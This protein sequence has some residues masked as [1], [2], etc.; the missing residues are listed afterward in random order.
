[1]SRSPDTAISRLLAL[2]VALMLMVS[3][4][5]AWAQEAEKPQG[6]GGSSEKGR[7]EDLM[8]V[9]PYVRF[10]QIVVPIIEGDRVT[11]QMA[12]TLTLQLFDAK[13]RAV[14]N[15]KR[16]LLTDA[17][18]KFLYGYFQQRVGLKTPINQVFL[19]ERLRQTAAGIVGP[20]LVKE[21]LIQQIYER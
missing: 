21:V 16:P 13:S 15:E 20:D 11:K 18:V 19:K 4:A 10:A 12:L 9:G 17:F 8:G 6:E 7:R 1:M 3:I 2:A 5:S 14:I